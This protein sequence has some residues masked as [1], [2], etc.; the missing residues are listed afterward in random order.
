ME[1]VTGR[2]VLVRATVLLVVVG[3]SG[4]IGVAALHQESESFAKEL[5]TA[6]GV[7]LSAIMYVVAWRWGTWSP[8]R[9]KYVMVTTFG[10]LATQL[11]GGPAVSEIVLLARGELVEVSVVTAYVGRTSRT[12][13]L[14]PVGDEPDVRGDLSTNRRFEE[15]QVVTVRVDPVGF[16]RPRLADDDA[17]FEMIIGV[18]SV[19]TLG[20]VIVVHGYPVSGATREMDDHGA[21]RRGV[22]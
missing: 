12:Y 17:I 6:G 11:A 20:V 8:E 21:R 14:R 18:T 19:L 16:V 2:A 13:D 4:G 15:G 5:M 9:G 1:G 10:L 7:G 22:A 3:A